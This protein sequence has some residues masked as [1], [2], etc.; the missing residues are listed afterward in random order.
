MEESEPKQPSG[1][2]QHN[3]NVKEQQKQCINLIKTLE[4]SDL[5]GFIDLLEK[6]DPK[7]EEFLEAVNKYRYDRN[8]GFF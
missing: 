6:R 7:A 4:T 8:L 2:E 1:L 5:A 3:I